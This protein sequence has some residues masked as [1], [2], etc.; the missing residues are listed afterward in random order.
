[1]AVLGPP[2]PYRID[3]LP[4]I[5]LMMLAGTK[6]G[7]TRRGPLFSS[8]ACVSSIVLMPPIPEPMAT[9]V[10]PRV[11]A[12]S[13]VRP[14]SSHR[15]N[16]GDQ[17]VLYERIYAPHFAAVEIVGEIETL[18]RG[19]NLHSVLGGV[20]RLDGGGAAAP[21]QRALP[22]FRHRVADG[23]EH[24]ESRD[25]Y[26]ALVHGLT[27]RGPGNSSA[28][29]RRR[30]ASGVPAQSGRARRQSSAVRCSRPQA[31]VDLG[32]VSDSRREGCRSY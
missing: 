16:A 10:R 9:P 21:R 3:R 20:E 23:R 26:P 5:M 19:R 2:N 27:C 22:G 12:P 6:K 7:D 13:S 14:A 24:A 8:V 1:M 25:G 30:G 29:Q 18:Y 11:S 32:E 31:W 17:S 4:E 28:S 15:L